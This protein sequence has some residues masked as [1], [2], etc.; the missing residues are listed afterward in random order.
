M[1]HNGSHKKDLK[2]TRVSFRIIELLLERGE[3]T[4]SEVAKEF[5]IAKSTAHRHLTTLDEI[6]YLTT[7]SENKFQI[8]LRFLEI[9]SR[10][11]NQR[12]IYKHS[13]EK[14]KDLASDTGERVQLSVEDHGKS[15]LIYGKSGDRAIQTD[16]YL[17]RR[18][19]LHTN[20]GGKAILAFLPE[21]QVS[22]IIAEHGLPRQT[23]NT[24]TNKDRLF[25]ELMT[26]RE[27]GIAFNDE[28]RISGLRAIGAPITDEE[29]TV[30]GSISIS[31][32][33]E[34]MRDERYKE[35]FPKMLSETTNEIELNIQ[36]EKNTGDFS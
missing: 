18:V 26:V 32:P 20:A 6:G 2:T 36:F 33:T 13:K 4:L 34:R 16:V 7:D 35:D 30:L 5:D 31:G 23:G 14:I 11:R 17:G 3:L 15:V 27:K 28:E 9:G 29:N 22:E 24:I 1:T 10:V 8:S 21:D 19:H 12:D 25:D